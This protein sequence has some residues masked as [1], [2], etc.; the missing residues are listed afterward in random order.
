[1]S[2]IDL[3]ADFTNVTGKINRRLHSSN[4][5]LPLSNRG[6]NTHKDM[7]DRMHFYASRT[8]DWALWNAGQRMVD[9]HFVFPLMHLDPAD[10]KNYYFEPTDEIIKDCV[11]SGVKVFYRMG[12]SIEHSGGRHFNTLPVE[13]YAKY[14]EIL[15]G[16]IR[17]YTQGWANG[18]HYDM[19]Y[20]E[21]WNEPDCGPVMWN[22]TLDD[23]I[24]FYVIVL[25][26]LKAEF[27]TLK[28]GGPAQCWL[29]T[30]F[31]TKL[32]LACKDA[33]IAPDFISWHCYTTNARDLIQQGNKGRK[34]LDSLGFT[35]TETCIN[36]WHYIVTWWGLHSEV[37]PQRHQ[38][39]FNKDAGLHSMESAAFNLAVLTG[40]Q[41]T[42][43]DTAF[44][45]GAAPYG[46]WGFYTADYDFNKNYFSMVL[47]GEVMENY[48]NKAKVENLTS[49]IYSL[50][51]L[52]EDGKKGALIISDY[53][54]SQPKIVVD[55]KTPV[56][57]KSVVVE[58]LDG[59]RN[60]VP[61]DFV[62]NGNELTLVKGKDGSAAFLVKFDF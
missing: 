46:A 59:E 36:E 1:M 25:K 48:T 50:A 28:I 35:K 27:P 12:T 52:S 19:E 51:A 21:I 47:Y 33:D 38:L 53:G 22:E 31:F 16:I 45:Y 29:N 10:P 40:W 49:T 5:T 60:I 23:F 2:T 55:L 56:A 43:L 9:T 17:H 34:L 11:E 39:G 42:A 14:A 41:D 7:F 44:Y 37:T 57:P 61:C 13:D 58:I 3:R 8:H 4:F 18:F 6:I 20:W 32:L 62:L 26:R 54:G 15:A 24:K 30:D